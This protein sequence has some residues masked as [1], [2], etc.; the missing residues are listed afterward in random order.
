MLKEFYSQERKETALENKCRWAYD[1]KIALKKYGKKLWSILQQFV[2][3]EICK[4]LWTRHL[5][6]WPNITRKHGPDER[7]L[8]SQEKFFLLQ[9]LSFFFY[10][11]LLLH[12][13]CRYRGLSLY[14]ITFKDTRIHTRYDFSGRVIGPSQSPLLDN[15][16]HSTTDRRPSH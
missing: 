15:T 8:G 1:V 11:D 9:F 4:H 3:G 6:F 2:K 12:A 5:N 7:V 10:F 14:L 16:Q 13:R